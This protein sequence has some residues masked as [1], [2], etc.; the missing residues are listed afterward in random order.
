MSG[1]YWVVVCIVLLLASFALMFA[2]DS[3]WVA[4]LLVSVVAGAESVEHPW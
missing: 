2:H 4:A 3:V 1:R